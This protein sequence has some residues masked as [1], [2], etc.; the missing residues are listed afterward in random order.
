MIS[1]RLNP[2]LPAYLTKE[3]FRLGNLPIT[4][5]KIDIGISSLRQLF[6]MFAQGNK[7]AKD[8]L[9]RFLQKEGFS[10]KEA[11]NLI[12]ELYGQNILVEDTDLS[13]YND[14]GEINRES[15][16]FAMFK[17]FANGSKIYD[18]LCSA[19]VVIL[20]LGAIGSSVASLLARAG[21]HNFVL[22]DC[23]VIE[24]SN[25]QRQILYKPQ[26][27]GHTK[28]EIAKRELQRINPNAHVE[29]I[30]CDFSKLEN[31]SELENASIA[32]STVDK[33][34][35]RIRI[36]V[37]QIFNA[38]NVP[39]IFSGFSEYVADIGPLVVPGKTACWNC[40]LSKIGTPS[41]S[42]K[43]VEV[44]PSFGPICMLAGSITAMEVVKY[45]CGYAEVKSLGS[46]ISVDTLNY[47]STV[48]KWSMNPR[49]VVCGSAR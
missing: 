30:H 45:V 35:R 33:P 8:E 32:I 6:L 7:V 37:N 36:E 44:T 46:T 17:G 13:Q 9:L 41:S 28:V 25:I 10:I 47:Q 22:V 14:A 2:T 26:D 43:N 18:K 48:T 29:I 38:L 19:K 20:G 5:K 12:S 40:V 11:E 23:D 1:Y 27:V 39:Y 49:C 3:E 34:M 24:L 31:Y 42:L 21:V 16:F 4:G 15:L